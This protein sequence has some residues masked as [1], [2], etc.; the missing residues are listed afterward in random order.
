[1]IVFVLILIFLIAYFVWHASRG[2]VRNIDS[3]EASI[4]ELL[5]RGY[6]CGYIVIKVSY[7]S[8][9]VQLR[10]YID[11]P[12][13]YGIQFVFPKV[14]WTKP[15]FFDV[16]QFC[17]SLE[18]AKCWVDDTENTNFLIVDFR[19]NTKEAFRC[20]KYILVNF[21]GVT[22]KT[23]LFVKLENATL[24]DDLIDS[25]D[26]FSNEPLKDTLKKS[27]RKVKNKGK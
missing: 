10:K 25:P 20:V 24:W 5:R 1:M 18:S 2:V 3:I 7:S 4:K 21:F 15:Y 13:K 8:K 14:E 9:F 11:A 6:D 16:K 22:D 17:N 27:I 26:Q 23:K 19:K 12:G